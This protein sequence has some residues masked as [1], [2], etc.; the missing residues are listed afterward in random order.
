MSNVTVPRLFKSSFIL[1]I[2]MNCFCTNIYILKYWWISK[3]FIFTS[4]IVNF[5]HVFNV[6]AK[7]M[8]RETKLFES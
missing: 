3:Y 6:N 1:K 2:Q 4:I 7:F 8:N 5:Y